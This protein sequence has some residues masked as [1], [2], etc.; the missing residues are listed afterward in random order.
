[1]DFCNHRFGLKK[2]CV[3]HISEKC[4]CICIGEVSDLFIL[5]FLC[6]RGMETISRVGNS[7]KI[8]LA[9]FEKGSALKG[10]NLLP[11]GANSFL[12]E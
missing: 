3:C 1:M 2:I 5:G 11:M 6:L 10:K 7:F 4:F 12:L 9:P 8:I